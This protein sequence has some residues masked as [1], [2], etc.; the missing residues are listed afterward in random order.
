M[1]ISKAY[2][3]T[4]YLILIFLIQTFHKSF[5]QLVAIEV[6]ANKDEFVNT[7]FIRSPWFFRWPK[8]NL[9]VHTLKHKF[10]VTLPVKGKQTFGAEDVGGSFT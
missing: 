5:S 8:V 6:L 2:V 4:Y 3:N 9:F 10:R 7:G 1:M